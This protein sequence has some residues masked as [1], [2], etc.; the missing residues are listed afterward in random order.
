MTARS[1]IVLLAAVP[2]CVSE[3]DLKTGWV[4]TETR[5]SSRLTL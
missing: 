2:A 5:S 4:W 3:M 1:D